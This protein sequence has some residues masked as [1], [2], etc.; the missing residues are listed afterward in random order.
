MVAIRQATANRH[1]PVERAVALQPSNFD[2]LYD[3]SVQLAQTASSPPRAVH[4]VRP[5]GA[6]RQ[7]WRRTSDKPP[8]CSPISDKKT[9]ETAKRTQR[10]VSLW[11]AFVP[12]GHALAGGAPRHEG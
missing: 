2:A 4:T 8:R 5:H 1:R 6:P 3:L 12:H 7:Q 9:A 11:D 10:V